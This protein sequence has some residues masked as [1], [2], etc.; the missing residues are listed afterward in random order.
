MFREMRRKEKLM[1]MEA[2]RRILTEAEYGTLATMGQD[3]YPYATPLN[4]VYMGN[5]IYFHTAQVGHK[6]DNM[7]FIPR[8]C[9]SVVGYHKLLADKFDTEYDSVVVYGMAAPVIDVAEKRCALLGLVEKYSSAWRDQG[10]AYID[11]GS[12][13]AAVCKIEIQHM[14]GKIGC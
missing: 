5:V 7:A 4:F 2:A 8:V 9:F 6:L 11:G 3:G 13:E 1:P 12:C 14:T 10:L